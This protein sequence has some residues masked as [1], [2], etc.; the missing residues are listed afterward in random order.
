[1]QRF[2][3]S[4]ITWISWPPRGSVRFD[5]AADGDLTLPLRGVPGIGHLPVF[6][7]VFERITGIIFSPTDLDVPYSWWEPDGSPD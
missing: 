3:L 7:T 5:H 6:L 4:P 1:M 2:G